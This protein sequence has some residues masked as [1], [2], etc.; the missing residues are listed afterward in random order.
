MKRV[1]GVLFLLFGLMAV[2][3]A[4]L[5][6][7]PATAFDARK[8]ELLVHTGSNYGGVIRTIEEDH[9]VRYPKVFDMVARRLGYPA[10]I[11]AGKY[12]VHKGMNLLSLVR[13]LRNGRQEPVNLVITKLRTKEDLASLAGRKLECDSLSVISFLDNADSLRRYGLDSNTVM[14]AVFPDTYTFFWNT[15]PAKIFAKFRDNYQKFWTPDR[16]RDAQQHGLN[17]QT[18]Y[19]L[20]SIVEEETLKKADKPKIASVYLN[21]LAKNMRLSADPTVKFALRDFGLKRIYFKHLAVPSPYN[22]YLNTGLPPGPICT[23]SEQ[24]IDAVITAPATTYLYFVASPT[25][26]GSSN[27]AE[28]YGQHLVNAK[29]YQAALDK[30]AT[31]HRADSGNLVH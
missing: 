18:A 28:T 15:T 10:K 1:L 7:G 30:L 25:L 16:I 2:V 22:T 31:Q 4:W 26:D 20:A 8:Y 21:R 17:P 9:V 24:T 3:A 6:L 13:M 19:I 27:F 5:L 14:T 23:P 12:T 11:R 29:A